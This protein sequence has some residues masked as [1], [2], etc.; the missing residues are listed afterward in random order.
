MCKVKKY[1]LD[2]YYITH[3]A[4]YCVKNENKEEEKNYLLDYYFI[5]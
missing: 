5:T 3:F 1:I 2:Y 4:L